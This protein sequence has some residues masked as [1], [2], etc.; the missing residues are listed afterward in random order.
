[1]TA[2][3]D[4]MGATDRQRGFI[5]DLLDN[6]LYT[7]AADEHIID[8]PRKASDLIDKLLRAPRKPLAAKP[9][10]RDAELEEALASVPKAK[11][12]IPANE[13]FADMFDA[14]I[15]NDLLFV[16]VKEYMNR[17]YVRRLHGSVGSFTRSKLTRSDSLTVLGIIKRNPYNYTK[18]FGEHHKCCGRCGAELTDDESRRLLLGPVCR[19]A[20]GV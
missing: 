2:I 13:I 8:N 15:N 10:A 5:L 3:I 18:L 20:F 1:M 12:A 17:L 14:K 7:L 6:R 9:A 4:L 11:Y 16:E 19:K